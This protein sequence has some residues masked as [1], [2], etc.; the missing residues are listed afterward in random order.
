MHLRVIADL[1]LADQAAKQ[2]IEEVLKGHYAPGTA[3]P[4]ERALARIF[5]VNRHVVREAL[6]RLEQLGLLSISREGGAKVLDFRRSAGLDLLAVMAEHAQGGREFAE[7]WRSV[8][9]M[10][11][12]TGADVVRLCTLN[13]GS[14]VRRDLVAI[15][16][17]MDEA[18]D[19]QRL[20]A[21]EVRFWERILDGADNI[22]YRLAFNSLLKG[23]LVMGQAGLEWSIEEIRQSSRVSLATA[24]A[25][26]DAAKAEADT[27]KMLRQTAEGFA[28]RAGL[29]EPVVKAKRAAAVKSRGASSKAKAA[30]KP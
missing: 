25:S 30:R 7:Y 14:E 16:T 26:G 18:S 5:R 13:A 21:L 15:A 29:T 3:L 20:F 4:P 22:A 23:V 10:R 6:Q 24:I 11:A 1:S 17:E 9:E 2:L 27:R 8:L 19:S 28:A 12:A